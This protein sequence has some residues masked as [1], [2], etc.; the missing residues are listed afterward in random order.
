MVKRVTTFRKIQKK[1]HRK[2]DILAGAWDR[3]KVCQR[4]KG[5]W[6]FRQREENTEGVYIFNHTF[7]WKKKKSTNLKFYLKI[8]NLS[9]D[10]IGNNFL[11]K[12]DYL[13]YL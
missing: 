10:G 2:D 1:F 11:I 6:N 12:Y 4:E 8:N 5:R 9:L 13:D 7:S 3:T